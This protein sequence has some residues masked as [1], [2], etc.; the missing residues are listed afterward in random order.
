M[1]AALLNGP[2][3]EFIARL[4]APHHPLLVVRCAAHG[5]RAIVADGRVVAAHGRPCC[6]AWAAEV[7]QCGR[8]GD[9]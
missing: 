3:A 9:A 6:A 5:R 2:A 4:R 8:G 7:A 1:K